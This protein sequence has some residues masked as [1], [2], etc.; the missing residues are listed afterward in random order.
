[1]NNALERIWNDAL[2]MELRYFPGNLLE[3]QRKSEKPQD[4]DVGSDLLWA[5]LFCSEPL[6]P[7]PSSLY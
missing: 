2:V 4:I 6:S 5:L 7:S 1:M 3:G